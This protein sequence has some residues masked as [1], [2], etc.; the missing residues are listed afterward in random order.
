MQVY[1]VAASMKPA[2]KNGGKT[3]SFNRLAPLAKATTALTEATNPTAVAATST[4][5]DVTVADYG[6][7][8]QV[9][10]LFNLTSID[11]DLK[12]HVELIG[13]NAGETIDELTKAVLAGNLTNQYAGQATEAAISA[14]D[15]LDGAEIR[16][17]VRQLKLNKAPKFEGNAY[18]GIVP[19]SSVYDLRGDSEWLDAHR[20]TDAT[21]IMTDEIGSL[22]GVRFVETNNEEINVDGGS[23]TVDVYSTFILGK[24]AYGIVDIAGTSTPKIIVKTSGANDTGNP[25]DMFSTVGWKA[26]WGGKVLNS[27]FGIELHAASSVGAN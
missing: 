22:H 13:Q 17:S 4:K 14:S 20:Y 6:N 10:S 23:G 2:P 19:V 16:K 12:E 18:I 9:G 25:L 24:G 3:V 8:I 11:V 7:F 21:N 26:T 1:G 5:V 27:A 15:T